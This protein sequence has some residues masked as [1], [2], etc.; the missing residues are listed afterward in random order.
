M[1]FALKPKVYNSIFES[2][3]FL[4]SS[5]IFSIGWFKLFEKIENLKVRKHMVSQ[6]V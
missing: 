6:L 3:T 4:F 1:G 2:L 5:S